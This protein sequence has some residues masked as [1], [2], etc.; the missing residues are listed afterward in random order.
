MPVVGELGLY[1]II[2]FQQIGPSG[3]INVYWYLNVNPSKASASAVA[4][5]FEGVVLTPLATTIQWSNIIHTEIEVDEV[6]ANDNFVTQASTVGAGGLTGSGL[7]NW[8][9]A[10]IQLNRTTKETR[11]GRKRIAG[12]LEENST[13]NAWTP[14]FQ[15]ALQA[16]ADLMVLD[17]SI[18]AVGDVFPVIVGKTYTIDIEGKKIENP[19]AEWLWNPI[20]TATAS[21]LLTTQ[22]TR[23][24]RIIT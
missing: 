22:G 11:N 3:M 2:D 9:A 24:L 10:S 19:P 8:V 13:Q 18:P 21:N 17:L 6:T 15:S 23:K 20:K 7:P 12:M 1:Q 16:V 5:A 4:T 14:S